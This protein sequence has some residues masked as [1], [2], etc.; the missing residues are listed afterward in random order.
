MITVYLEILNPSSTIS[1]NFPN[2]F[3][4]LVF[5]FENYGLTLVI[6]VDTIVKAGDGQQVT[7]IYVEQ[8]KTRCT[9]TI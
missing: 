7:A 5:P 6:I 8:C 3:K 2:A 1:C 9:T 4:F